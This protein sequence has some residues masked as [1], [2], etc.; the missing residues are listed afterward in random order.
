VVPSLNYDPLCTRAN[1]K[2]PQKA[3]KKPQQ[4]PSSQSGVKSVGLPTHTVKKKIDYIKLVFFVFFCPL[5]GF[6]P[7]GSFYVAIF[8]ARDH[9]K[10]TFF[11]LET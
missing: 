8:A 10:S 9:D 1:G 7:L 6:C 2:S 11:F 3:Q 4:K 5:G